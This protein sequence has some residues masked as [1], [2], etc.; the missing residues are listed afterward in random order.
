MEP[1]TILI[2]GTG[3][4]GTTSAANIFR[5]Q[6]R[7][8]ATHE[9]LRL[10]WRE[11]GH[12]LA[13]YVGWL[14]TRSSDEMQAD[15]AF[16]LL[17]IADEL[18]DRLRNL[19]I[20]VLERPRDQVVSSYENWRPDCNHWQHHD[21]S[22]WNHDEWD[23]C[24]P[25]FDAATRK[26]A[27]GMYWDFYHRETRRLE[28][29]H[30]DRVIKMAAVDLND[31]SKVR[32]MLEFCGYGNPVVRVEHANRSTAKAPPPPALA[33][34]AD[35]PVVFHCPHGVEDRI[36]RV[37]FEHVFE[38]ALAATVPAVAMDA[39]TVC[40]F[41]NTSTPCL[42]ERQAAKL[43]LPH[44]EILARDV[45]NWSWIEKVRTPLAAIESGRITS[46]Y[47]LVI[48][49]D[50]TVFPAQPD[51]GAMA[52]YLKSTGAP[53][54]FG[55]TCADWPPSPVIANWERRQ[56]IGC[57]WTHLTASGVFARTGNYAAFLREILDRWQRER[58]ADGPGSAT[59]RFD[60]QLAWR[61]LRK[62]RHP[63]IAVDIHRRIFCRFDHFV[64]GDYWA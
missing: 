55:S 44:F 20:V 23:E 24:Y 43:E 60:D 31:P 57:V 10:A 12:R 21:G 38:N 49:G 36:R 4:C 5:A 46:E 9:G 42:V 17:P 13:E 8:T 37:F 1:A 62:E 19:R 29:E 11:A 50:D 34:L 64:A 45:R 16:Y 52:A 59:P 15:A 26:E 25:K 14:D 33:P 32:S 61:W 35:L 39:V 58:P 18:L 40:T 41:N 7:T 48:D 53:A 22:L 56:H 2:L 6:N 30:P 54:L 28:R 47:V 3:R 27:I 63:E 51:G